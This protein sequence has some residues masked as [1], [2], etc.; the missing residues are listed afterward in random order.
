[1]F[2]ISANVATVTLAYYITSTLFSERSRS[3]DFQRFTLIVKDQLLSFF[4]FATCRFATASITVNN[5]FLS[6]GAQF[7]AKFAAFSRNSFP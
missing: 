3:S 1:M 2:A 5:N 4:L 6:I 7:A